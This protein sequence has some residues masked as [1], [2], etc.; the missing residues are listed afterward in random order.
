MWR[1]IGIWLLLARA[2]FA[3]PVAIKARPRACWPAGGVLFE[4][5]QRATGKRSTATT[6][7]FA[8]GAWRTATFDTDGKPAATGKG[9]LEKYQVARIVEA[10]AAATW[11]VTHTPSTCTLSPRWS[12]YKW[13][14]RVVFTD[15]ACSG[16]A[17]DT[18]SAKAIDL[19]DFYVVP[20]A[21]DD[22]A[23]PHRHGLPRECLDNP[24]ASACN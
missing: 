5:D 12:T 21:L 3:E 13:K 16:D 23:R 10:L 7:L 4:I 24:L 19:V 2:A 6:L 22:D 17:L 1:A 14:T 20:P 9:C 18:D 15:R 8:N 11:K